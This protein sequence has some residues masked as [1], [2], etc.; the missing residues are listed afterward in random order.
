MHIAEIV[1]KMNGLKIDRLLNPAVD[2]EGDHA[3]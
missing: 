2:D 1:I 3:Q